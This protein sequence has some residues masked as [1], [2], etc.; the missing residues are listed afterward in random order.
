MKTEK[1]DIAMYSVSDKLLDKADL[2]SA[3]R[4]VGASPLKVR[5]TPCILIKSQSDQENVMF[6]TGGH[7]SAINKWCKVYLKCENF[8]VTNSFKIR[9]RFLVY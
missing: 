6:S 7:K 1:F 3:R 5:R 8:Q 9:G 4:I 2:E